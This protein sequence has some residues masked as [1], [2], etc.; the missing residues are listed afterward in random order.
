MKTKERR[1]IFMTYEEYLRKRLEDLNKLSV[2]DKGKE[3]LQIVNE[4]KGIDEIVKELNRTKEEAEKLEHDSLKEKH[5]YEE[6][7][8]KIQNEINRLEHDILKEQNR[9]DEELLK[10]ANDNK[11]NDKRFWK[12]VAV[13]VSKIALYVLGMKA[14]LAME[15][16]NFIN[17][18]LGKLFSNRLPFGKL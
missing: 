14:V 7:C 8:L 13:E 9:H 18:T 17:T 3:R 6:E 10:I 1:L 5:H 11:L 12:D 2:Y 4:M 16:D 15:K